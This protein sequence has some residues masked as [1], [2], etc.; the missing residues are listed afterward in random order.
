[1]ILT[2]WGWQFVGIVLGWGFMLCLGLSLWSCARDVVQVSHRLHQ[3]PCPRCRFF[4]NNPVLKCTVHPDTA[5]S[6]QAIH[7]PD[8]HD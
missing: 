5:L 6:E 4:T 2:G 1:M 3:V 8:Y 7:C